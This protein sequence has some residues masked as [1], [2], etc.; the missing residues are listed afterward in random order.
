MRERMIALQQRVLSRNQLLVLV[1]LLG[2]ARKG[3]T[4]DDF[5]AEIQNNITIAEA[6]PPGSPPAAEGSPKNPDK[7]ASAFSISFVGGDPRDA[8][9][10]CSGFTSMLL[11]ENLK[12]REQIAMSTT[13]FLSRQLADAK[14]G[15]DEQDRKFAAFKTMHLGQLPSDMDNNLKILGELNSQLDAD[16]QLLNRAQQDKV[17]AESLLAQQLGTWKSSQIFQTSETI[18]QRLVGLQTQLVAMQTQYTENYPE[19]IKLK[20]D[21]AALEAKQ[22]EMS[23]DQKGRPAEAHIDG[24]VKELP[25][26]RQLRQR[27]HQNETVIAQTTREQKQVQEKIDKYQSRLT[28]IPKVEEEFKQLIRDNASAHQIYDSLV[29]SKSQSEM[30]T[31]LERQ[32]QG[33]QLQLVE[34]ANLPT[35]PS[36]PN[37]LKFMAVGLGGGL[38]FG[39]TIAGW[40]EWRDKKIRDERDVHAGLELPMLTHIPWVGAPAVDQE[41][42]LRG[43]FKGLLGN[44]HV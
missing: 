31:D 34:E 21:I 36:F 28:L 14:N 20:R 25:E 42:G 2:L 38:A 16:T 3:K 39:I 12:T 35:S 27:I 1:N 5:V 4:A 9:R 41:G 30:Q 43:R 8:Q 40:L 37:R 15:L 19:L 26:I 44:A 23:T 17:Y 7:D 24:D 13:D 10:I 18:E 22:K 29:V 33:E 6:D 32:Q 11:A